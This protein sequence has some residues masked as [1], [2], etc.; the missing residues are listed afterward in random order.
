MLL[1]TFFMSLNAFGQFHL[2]SPLVNN[3]HSHNKKTLIPERDESLFS[4]GTTLIASNA[5]STNDNGISNRKAYCF[6]S[7]HHRSQV[8]FPVGLLPVRSNPGSLPA[9]FKVLF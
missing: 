8:A 2:L 4:R 6:L 3:I 5:S 7:I 9:G 1:Q